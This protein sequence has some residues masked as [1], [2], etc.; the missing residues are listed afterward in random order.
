MQRSQFTPE[1]IEKF[2]SR[3]DTSGGPEACWPW[4]GATHP[5]GYGMFCLAARRYVRAN[6]VAYCL[7]HG[8]IAD[9]L[10]AAHECDAPG[11][12][13]P[14]HIKAITQLENIA[15][16]NRKGRQDH[17]PNA[18]R[19]ARPPKTGPARGERAPRARL[20]AE[21]VREIRGR[22]ARGGISQKRLAA[23][24]GVWEYAIWMIV[25]G[26]SWQHV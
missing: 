10:V 20:T 5:H 9:G 1:Q 13:N 16:R 18:P 12:C 17:G 21:Q 22:Y 8:E 25:H 6:R 11:C 3:V 7:V 14:A 2:W 26:K 23:E 19:W 15:D 24:Y 4:T